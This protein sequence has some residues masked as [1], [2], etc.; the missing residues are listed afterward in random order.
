MARRY[1]HGDLLAIVL[2]CAAV[3]LGTRGAVWQQ[4]IGDDTPLGDGLG[5]GRRE[6]LQLAELLEEELGLAMTPMDLARVLHVRAT[7]GDA[8]RL[9]AALLARQDKAVAMPCQPVLILGVRHVGA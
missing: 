5:F 6:V 1:S 8:A 2:D 4:G 3:V 9:C 7:V